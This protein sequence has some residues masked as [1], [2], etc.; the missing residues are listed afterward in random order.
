MNI[1]VYLKL[2]FIGRIHCDLA[3]VATTQS[4][5]DHPKLQ[6]ALDELRTQD[7]PAEDLIVYLKSS[8][9]FMAI[10]AMILATERDDLD[11][12]T[13]KPALFSHI[14]NP[15]THRTIAAFR[16]I[17]QIYDGPTIGSVLSAV[18]PPWDDFLIDQAFRKFVAERLASG[19][20]L[21]FGEFNREIESWD[22]DDVNPLITP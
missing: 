4:I 17:P 1:T 3:K 16:F 21:T 18:Y 9:D 14:A 8:N 7:I 2:R 22:L 19:E 10:L 5:I 6:R 20:E 15:E 11:Q 13:L 12:A